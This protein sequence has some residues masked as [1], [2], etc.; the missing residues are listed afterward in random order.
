[1]QSVSEGQYWLDSQGETQ[2][3]GGVL[4]GLKDYRP[5]RENE[6]FPVLAAL[7]S[8]IV[9]LDVGVEEE[10]HT[11][12]YVG[13][14][15]WSISGY[16]YKQWQTGR[17]SG[18]RDRSKPSDDEMSVLAKAIERDFSDQKI[19]LKEC[20]F[21]YPGKFQ[22]TRAHKVYSL[23]VGD[24]VRA[25][26]KESLHAMRI[27][28]AL[29]V[30]LPDQR[31]IPYV[32]PSWYSHVGADPLT[33]AETV[34]P[35][36]VRSLHDVVPVLLSC[37]REQVMIVHKCKH[38]C[39]QRDCLEHNSSA[40]QHRCRLVTSC[41][42]HQRHDC[43]DA[44]CGLVEWHGQLVHCEQKTVGLLFDHQT[45]FV[46]NGKSLPLGSIGIDFAHRQK[47]AA[48]KENSG[49]RKGSGRSGSGD[50]RGDMK[51]NKRSAS[52]VPDADD[53]QIRLDVRC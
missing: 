36:P 38:V 39:D 17:Q 31:R 10:H 42:A 23:A 27:N 6:P 16:K 21:E 22:Q 11:D 8:Y 50:A 1:M 46:A 7:S 9:G 24:L 19:D 40:C 43:K 4:Q 2:C 49:E 29:S 5:G 14:G 30:V 48:Q 26:I 20:Q 33:G 47:Q 45:G 52:R 15:D 18:Q 53:G 32:F 37:V 34:R 13:A 12:T 51:E 41:P 28:K 35:R 44:S 25:E 3:L